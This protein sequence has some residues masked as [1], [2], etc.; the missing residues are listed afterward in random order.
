MI[1]SIDLPR[2]VIL[3]LLLWKMISVFLD[4]MSHALMYPIQVSWR[5]DTTNRKCNL[6]DGAVFKTLLFTVQLE[7]TKKVF[8]Y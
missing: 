5:H 2:Q 8:D 3:K 1:H 4:F 6:F 7:L